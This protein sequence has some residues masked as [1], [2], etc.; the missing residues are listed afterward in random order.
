MSPDIARSSTSPP[1]GRSAPGRPAGRLDWR[2]L[3]SVAASLAYPFL[4]YW[5]LSQRR[6]WFGLLLTLTALLGLSMWLPQRRVQVVALL[7]VFALAAVA[8]AFA[9]T[10]SLLFL[11]PVCVNLS[12][13]WCF[14]RTLAPGREALITRFARLEHGEPDPRVFAYT[15]R[16]TWVWTVFFVIMAAVSGALAAFG[17]SEAW[18][19]FTAVGNY[20]CVAVLFAIEYGYRRRRFPR[21]DHVSPRQQML[22]MRAGLRNQ[23]Q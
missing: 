11:P 22:L 3:L 9:A 10:T 13:A 12:L 4:V 18:V 17:A 14:G 21:K 7:G 5:V 8:L 2:V 1:A 19:W 23:R 16:L 20:L 6:P 15:R